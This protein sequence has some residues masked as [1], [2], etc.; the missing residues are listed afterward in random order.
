MATV[1]VIVAIPLVTFL[2]VAAV[3]QSHLFVWTVFAPKLLY[4]LFQL[5]LWAFQLAGVWSV[6][7]VVRRFNA[8]KIV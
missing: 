7:L 3:H 4:M 5:Y 6:T 2:Y 8:N 1:A